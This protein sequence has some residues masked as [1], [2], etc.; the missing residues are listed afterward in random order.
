M[1]LFA[2]A[3][4]AGAGIVL[5]RR[6][7]EISQRTA[8]I[9]VAMAVMPDIPHLLPIIGWSIFGDGSMAA[10][11]DYAIASAGQPPA[12]PP[13]VDSWSHN[14]HC[15][16]HSA[17]VAGLVTLL[18]WWWLGRLWLALLGW[19]SHIVIDVFTHA[20]DYFPSPVLYPFTRAGFDGIAWNTPWFVAANYSLLATTYLCLW[21]LRKT[22]P[23]HS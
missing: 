5:A 2:H 14:L 13:D 19:W 16:P 21:W 1:D 8:A 18:S 9:T 20:A 22:V 6:H 11:R 12:A 4:W 15:I 7:R 17:V 10:L 23:A 3:L